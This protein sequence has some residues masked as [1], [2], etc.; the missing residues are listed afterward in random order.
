MSVVVRNEDGWLLDTAELVSSHYKICCSLSNSETTVSYEGKKDLFAIHQPFR[1]DSQF[2]KVVRELKDEADSGEQDHRK[3]RKRKRQESNPGEMAA[4]I[5][6]EQVK[7][8]LTSTLRELVEKGFKNGYFTEKP[9]MPLD[10]NLTARSASHLEGPGDA[11]LSR[12]EETCHGDV[13]NNHKGPVNLAVAE[14]NDEDLFNRLVN[15]EKEVA[16]IVHCLDA[17]YLIPPQSQFLMSDI[18]CLRPLLED[19]KKFDVIVIDPPWKNKS[20]KRK[21]KYKTLNEWDF[22]DLPVAHLA[23]DGCLLVI[24][25]TNKQKQREFVKDS[26]FPHWSAVFEAEWHWIKVTRHG[27]TV[28]P[29]E[30]PHKKPY[31][32]IILGR[33]RRDKKEMSEEYEDEKMKKVDDKVLVSVPCC[34]HSKKPPLTEILKDYLPDDS[35]CLEMFARNLTPGWTSWG[36]EVLRFQHSDFFVRRESLVSH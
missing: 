34:V 27:E 35:C 23:A 2:A 28:F 17:D 25:V 14:W 3:K 12:C 21:K 16:S 32:S 9:R 20:V 15:H 33:V 7:G 31:E 5:Y 26:W 11:L 18:T 10:N 13:A 1:M 4:D 36:N 19:N 8:F 24:W 22:Y 30:S 6:H 29:M